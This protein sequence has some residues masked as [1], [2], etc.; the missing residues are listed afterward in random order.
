MGKM[1][2]ALAISALLFPF[3]LGAQN[4][5]L[6]APD[7]DESLRT[8][9]TVAS[10]T[11]SLAEDGADAPQD[12]VAAARADYRRLLTVLYA[13]GFYGG[14]ISILV[15]GVEA[16]SI[17]PLM[18]RTSL[19]SVVL[20]VDP[21]PRFTF[22]R[23]DITPLARG[24]SLPDAFATGQI[25]ESGVVGDAADAAVEEWRNNSRPLAQTA[26]QSITA[27]HPDQ[28]L[29]VSIIVDPGPELRF[30]IV[31]VEGNENVRTDRI[32]GTARRGI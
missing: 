7:A 23:T 31:S 24:T 17:D 1:R 27:R 4:V 5:Q 14:T 28:A 22:G 25:A 12:Y 32:R 11:L 19:G 20:S 16:S 2:T 21:G 30:G 9:L 3:G 29:D 10:L 26:G 15:D 13:Q 6:N 8:T 18:P